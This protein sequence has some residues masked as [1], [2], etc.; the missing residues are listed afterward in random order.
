M[1]S[2]RVALASRTPMVLLQRFRKG[3][4]ISSVSGL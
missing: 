4:E 2:R 1:N 3:V